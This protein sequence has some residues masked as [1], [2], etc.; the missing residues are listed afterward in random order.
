MRVYSL[1]DTAYTITMLKFIF[2]LFFPRINDKATFFLAFVQKYSRTRIM[3]VYKVYVLKH[4]T[5]C[6][7]CGLVHMGH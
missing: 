1:V 7:P 5:S 4:F 6:T 2:K 3:Q